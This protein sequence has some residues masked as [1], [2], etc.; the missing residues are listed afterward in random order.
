MSRARFTGVNPSRRFKVMAWPE[1]GSEWY[2]EVNCKTLE[3][4]EKNAELLCRD[5]GRQIV[6]LE[7]L[8][9]F[10]PP[11]HPE[12]RKVPWDET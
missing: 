9:T 8:S 4:A 2:T 11:E 5:R 7:C 3:S 1:H 10:L 12:V 6:V